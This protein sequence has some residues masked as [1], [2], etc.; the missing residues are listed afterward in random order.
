MASFLFF[1]IYIYIRRWYKYWFYRGQGESPGSE[2]GRN[3]C[4]KL[5]LLQ[6][7]HY[8]LLSSPRSGS[9]DYVIILFLCSH[10][11]YSTKIYK[12]TLFYSNNYVLWS[13]NM[14]ESFVI[15]FDSICDNQRYIIGPRFFSSKFYILESMTFYDGLFEV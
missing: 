11:T 15:S 6:N 10:P 13:I 12:Y 1:N 3:C 14:V 2:L 5:I 7:T 8:S 4:Q 9:C